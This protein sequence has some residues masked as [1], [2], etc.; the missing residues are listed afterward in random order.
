M[1]KA[2]SL[3]TGSPESGEPSLGDGGSISIGQPSADPGAGRESRPTW[4]VNSVAVG[5]L[6][7]YLILVGVQWF[8]IDQDDLGWARR[9]ELLTGVEALAFAA[10]GVLLGTTVQRQVTR[11]AEDQAAQARNEADAA[12]ADADRQ[13]KDGEK[14]RALHNLIQA[15]A[16]E[17]PPETPPGESA[18]TRA[19]RDPAGPDERPNPFAEL[20]R[21]AQQFD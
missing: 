16:L 2:V 9:S 11:K 1:S 15:K 18:V 10:A 17:M 7:A 5:L 20:L 19:G 12:R 6:A 3:S 13:H 14:G 8:G 4:L 21:F